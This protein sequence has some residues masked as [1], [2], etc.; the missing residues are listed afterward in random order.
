LYRISSDG[1]LVTPISPE[2]ITVREFFVPP[3]AGFALFTGDLENRMASQQLFVVTGTSEN[4]AKSST[5]RAITNSQLTTE[6]G[7]HGIQFSPT[8]THV[9]DTHSNAAIPPSLRLISTMPSQTPIATLAT[10]EL[11]LKEQ[12][13]APET[14][15]I[16][17]NDGVTLPAMIIKPKIL[18]DGE[19]VPVVI[20]TYG[21]PQ[22]PVVS[23]RWAGTQALYRQLLAN[24]GI[25]TLV[26]DNRSSAGRTMADT[27]AIHKRFGEV[28]FQ[29]V[30]STVDYLKSL[31]W[32]DGDRLA[33]R[34]WS[35][36][37][38]LTLYVMTHCDSFAAGI[39]GGS[40]T[41]FREYDAFYTE[42]YMGL[43]ASNP[44][45]YDQTNL[46]TLADKLHGRLLMIHGEVDDNVHPLGTL[47]MAKALQTAGKQ[48]DLMI[49]PGS[50]HS[51]QNPNHVWHL[52]NLTHEFLIRN[53]KGK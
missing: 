47:R 14:I 31:T 41:D 35:Y 46:T 32:V 33:I 8:G 9:V 17:A 34:G 4:E 26:V 48:F 29:D 25:A 16:P 49:Y 39:A 53:L 28:E 7:W 44:N 40:V 36:G 13:I 20:E 27:W 21:G 38:Y 1:T 43:P 10:S 45:G 37:G 3:H 19:R 18:R 52:V 30:A 6:S 51:V 24:S 2:G 50:A 23:D 11:L 42:R 15:A 12:I 22:A 5:G